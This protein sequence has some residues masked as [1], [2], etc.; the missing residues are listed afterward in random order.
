MGAAAKEEEFTDGPD[1]S[2]ST[3]Q[4]S[5]AIVRRVLK[6]FVTG[7]ERPAAVQVQGFLNTLCSETEIAEISL[8]VGAAPG[9]K[10]QAAVKTLHVYCSH[11]SVHSAAAV[12]CRPCCRQPAAVHI[13]SLADAELA[14][15]LF[16]KNICV[17]V[18]TQLSYKHTSGSKWQ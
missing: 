12:P 13:G 2:P 10:Q 4:V 17:C 11:R 3:K 7:I 5:S 16:S 15:G 8:K 14:C 18:V 1:V 6:R 9:Q